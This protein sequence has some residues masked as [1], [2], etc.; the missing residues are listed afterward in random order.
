VERILPF[1]SLLSR[2]RFLGTAGAATLTLASRPTSAEAAVEPAAMHSENVTLTV[3]GRRHDLDLDPRV[4]LLDA[5]REHL[6]LTGTKKGCDQGQCGACTVIVNGQRI[7]SCLT[8]AV[9]HA[10]DEITTIEG[11]EKDGDLHP[12]QVAFVHHDGLQCGYCT[13][14]QICSAVALLAEH[15]AGW[16][17]YA[18]ADVATAPVLTDAEIA[19]RMSGNICRCSA[20][21]NIV[22]AIREVAEGG[23]T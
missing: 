12:M 5:L 21:P 22:S 18:T 4:T 23:R 17:S 14:G 19:E 13:P 3:N 15:K 20:Y 16:P 10:G 8:L 9:M 1:L 6:G 11:L 7:N 2:R